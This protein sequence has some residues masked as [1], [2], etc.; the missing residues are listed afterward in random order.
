MKKYIYVR[1]MSNINKIYSGKRRVC[2]DFEKL[3]KKFI[4]KNA[5]EKFIPLSDSGS[6]LQHFFPEMTISP[7]YLLPFSVVVEKINNFDFFSKNIF[8]NRKKLFTRKQTQRMCSPYYRQSTKNKIKKI[9]RW[10]FRE[11]P[12]SKFSKK[13]PA[14]SQ[15]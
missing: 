15:F 2:L 12:F 14:F 4:C 10:P 8:F 6:L 7:K 5:S 11:H 9:Y 3:H 1:Y 13:P